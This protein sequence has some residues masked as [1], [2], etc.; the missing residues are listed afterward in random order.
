MRTY[1]FPRL[2]DDEACRLVQY[3]VLCIE[4]RIGLPVVAQRQQAW[5]ALPVWMRARLLVGAW[6]RRYIRR[7]RW[8]R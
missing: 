4:E 7:G 2:T 5:D 3:R 8:G 6:L 1:P